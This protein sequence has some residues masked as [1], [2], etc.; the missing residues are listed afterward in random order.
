MTGRFARIAPKDSHFR[1]TFMFKTNIIQHNG[2]ERYPGR[3]PPA[4]AG[5]HAFAQPAR[6]PVEAVVRFVE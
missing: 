2:E 4:R 6:K 5:E 3:T 1:L